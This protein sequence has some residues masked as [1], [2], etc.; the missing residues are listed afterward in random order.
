MIHHYVSVMSVD[1]CPNCGSDEVVKVWE[2][3]ILQEAGMPP[4]F[5]GCLDCNEMERNT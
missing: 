4:K 3:V 5:I 1:N 2:S